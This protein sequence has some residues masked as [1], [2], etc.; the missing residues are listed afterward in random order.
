MWMFTMFTRVYLSFTLIYLSL[1]MFTYV[2]HL[3]SV[4]L[5]SLVFTYV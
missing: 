3:T 4:N 1:Q 5:S 2:Y